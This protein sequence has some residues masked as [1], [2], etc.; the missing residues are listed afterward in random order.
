M[1]VSQRDRLELDALR[2]IFRETSP[3][4]GE[5]FLKALVQGLGRLLDAETTFVARVLDDPPTRV[6]GLSAWKDGAFKDSW[7]YELEGN[8][9]QLTYD[10]APTYIPCDLAKD[11]PKKKDSGY[12]SYLG[13][14]LFDAGG[15]VIGHIAVY[16]SRVR[17]ADDFALEIARLCGFRAEAKVQRLIE[18]DAVHQELQALRDSD[19]R[20][21]EAVQVISH[22][23]RTPLAGVIGYL[24]L[25]DH[26]SL[27][28]PIDSYVTSAMTGAERLLHFINQ[29]LDLE[30]ITAGDTKGEE[31]IV[32][33][34]AAATE[35]VQ[36]L[37][38]LATDWEV[39]FAS[40]SDGRR[41]CILGDPGHIQRL[42]DN[43]MSNALKFSPKGGT[44]TIDTSADSERVHV[45]VSDQ[46]PGIPKDIQERIFERF[47]RA[48]ANDDR[49]RGGAGLGLSIAKAI[50]E[51]LGGEIGFTSDPGSGTQFFFDLPL[52]P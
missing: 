44:V 24:S 37:T 28:D 42:F 12:E 51:D 21:T 14:P 47:A 25:L 43:L 41:A 16:S 46:G 29:Q 11:F 32:D 33:L 38:P 3:L 48:P 35:A 39:T 52:A 10:G 20:K 15:K 1:D 23:L 40:Q 19:L 17:K 45:A 18:Q 36:R 4:I 6:R 31:Q 13:I 22:D 9:C 49:Q 50:V 2:D 5:A 34:A 30:K 26:Q 7:E 8:P 27:P